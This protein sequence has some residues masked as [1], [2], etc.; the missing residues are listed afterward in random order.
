MKKEHRLE[1]LVRERFKGI[2]WAINL[3]AMIKNPK[4][5]EPL[6]YLRKLRVTYR[7]VLVEQAANHTGNANTLARLYLVDEAIRL[8]KLEGARW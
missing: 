7:K 6:E 1:G 4:S 2:D 5:E 3:S 8:M